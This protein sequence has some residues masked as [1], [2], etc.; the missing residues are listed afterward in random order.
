[1][2]LHPG[3]GNAYGSIHGTVAAIA[4][5]EGPGGLFRGLAPSLVREW[6]V[7]RGIGRRGRGGHSSQH[8]NII[9]PIL[10]YL[11]LA[12]SVACV[13][14]EENNSPALRRASENAGHES[15]AAG[16][17]MCKCMTHRC[18]Y[19]YAGTIKARDTLI[20]GGHIPVRWHRPDGQLHAEGGADGA[21]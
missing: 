3:P 16:G 21:L 1:M 6:G 9:V 19:H 13:G 18:L 4:A 8:S 14:G 10:F 15:C 12:P 7:G 5:S 20:A 11:K 2:L 17:H